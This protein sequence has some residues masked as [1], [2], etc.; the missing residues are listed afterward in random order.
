M[1][2]SKCGIL[3][4]EGVRVCPV[5]GNNIIMAAPAAPVNQ[6]A[7]N[8]PVVQPN[9][10]K[11]NGTG[12]KIGIA[13][14]VAV[15]VVVAAVVLAIKFIPKKQAEEVQTTT[16]QT[17]DTD[18][19]TPAGQVSDELVK[20]AMKAY[21]KDLSQNEGLKAVY[22]VDINK[23]GIPEVIYQTAYAIEQFVITY[24]EKSG[25]SKLALAGHSSTPTEI[26]ISE[27][28][29][30]YSRDDGH[31]QGTAFYHCA[32]IYEIDETGFVLTEKIE[33]DEPTEEIDWEDETAFSELYKKYTDLFEKEVDKH[34]SGKTFK[35]FSDVSVKE[36]IAG[37]L[38]AVLAIE[39][40]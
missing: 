27:D 7:G 38:K 26:F 2:C 23:D 17:Q 32:E 5:C 8:L 33:G 24:T 15:I 4:A 40:P 30:F 21:E 37:H 28:N 22:V 13:I 14:A 36:D 6:Q 16:A 25:L 10:P 18:N 9:S 31:N 20:E 3:V 39:I 11:K 29:C 19:K 12:L 35:L 34:I 1:I